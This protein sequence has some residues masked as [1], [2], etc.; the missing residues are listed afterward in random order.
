M[1]ALPILFGWV[2]LYVS[3]WIPNLDENMLAYAVGGDM[4]LLA[5]L[6]VLGGDFWD[7]V[8]ALFV[9]SDRV[10]SSTA[11]QAE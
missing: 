1:F 10:C 4:L 6:F 9:Y 7:K 8:R 3:D 2:T 5:S 11:Q